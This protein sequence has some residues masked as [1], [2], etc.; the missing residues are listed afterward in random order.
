MGAANSS[1][2]P[3][4]LLLNRGQSAFATLEC[5]LSSFGPETEQ[6]KQACALLST[7]GP[8]LAGYFGMAQPP[9]WLACLLYATRSG[10]QDRIYDT[11]SQLS[12]RLQGVV[13][14]AVSFGSLG[15]DVRTDGIYLQL[16]PRSSVP[17]PSLQ[18]SAGPGLLV[19]RL[20]PEEDPR[21]LYVI[22]VDPSVDVT[23]PYERRV[24]EERVRS[25]LTSLVGSRLDSPKVELELEDVLRAAVEVWDLWRDTKAKK[26]LRNSIKS[27][28]RTILRPIQKGGLTVRVYQN[29]ITIEG[30]DPTTADRVRRYFSSAAWRQGTVDLWSEAVQTDFSDLAEGW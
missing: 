17:M 30:I 14:E 15:I 13:I 18:G 27:Y 7:T 23:D 1:V 10:Q 16:D 24:L 21:P 5:K 3:D 22:P 4:L 9:S 11:L 28:V 12:D 20:P 26:C 29:R 8:Y 2:A 6:S 25:A 19:M